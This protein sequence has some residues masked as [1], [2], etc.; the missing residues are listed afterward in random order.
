MIE[1][2]AFPVEP[3][4]VRETELDFDKLAQSESVVALS[5]G[6]IG[7][8][9]NL[10]EGEPNG[11]PGTYLG[12]FYETRPLPYAEAGYGYPEDQSVVNVT[13]GKIMRLLVEDEPFD[14]RYGRLLSPRAG[15][16][17]GGED[18]PRSG[19]RRPASA[20]ARLRR[21]IA[22][23]RRAAGQGSAPHPDV[24]VRQPKPA[25][26]GCALTLIAPREGNDGVTP[27]W[28]RRAQWIAVIAEHDDRRDWDR[29]L[30]A[31][32][33][34]RRRTLVEVGIPTGLNT[35]ASHRY[36]CPGHPTLLTNIGRQR[37]WLHSV[38]GSPLPPVYRAL[39]NMTL[40]TGQRARRSRSSGI[41]A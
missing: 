7:L 1:H 14:V 13:N 25:V 26:P 30:F 31:R 5:N 24:P 11:L 8:R 28:Q 2:P 29:R 40:G 27:L 19:R 3:W 34:Q 35:P 4:V 10:D 41:S 23:G 33:S 18:Q 32:S 36:S 22:D 21:A 37:G 12:G 20:S 39:V 17:Q 15:A 38:L 9:G 16:P 6:H